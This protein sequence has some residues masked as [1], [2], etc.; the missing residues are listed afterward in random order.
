MYCVCVCVSVCLSPFCSST[1]E[2]SPFCHSVFDC[3]SPFVVPL[4][5][6]WECVCAGMC[7]S[8][9]SFC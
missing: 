5:R 2:V 3:L 1:G 9:L 4:V 7:V 8:F 6:G